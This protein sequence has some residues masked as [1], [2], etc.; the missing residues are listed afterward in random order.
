MRGT[1]RRPLGV[2]YLSGTSRSVAT[3]AFNCVYLSWRSVYLTPPSEETKKSTLH[4]RMGVIWLTA[5][6]IRI[7]YTSLKARYL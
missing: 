6:R 7:G 1:K 2:Y 4:L 3:S 5:I